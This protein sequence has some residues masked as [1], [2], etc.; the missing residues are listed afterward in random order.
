MDG[1][2]KIGAEMGMSVDFASLAGCRHG[3]SAEKY[4][5]KW[6]SVFEEAD[7]FVVTGTNLQSEWIPLIRNAIVAGKSALILID[8]NKVEVLNPLLAHFGMTITRQ[9]IANRNPSEGQNIVQ[10][11]RDDECMRAPDLF[12]GV[13]S[14]T[15]VLP[16][17]IWYCAVDD[18][19]PVLTATERQFVVNERDL[20]NNSEDPRQSA[21][22]VTWHGPK[23]QKIVAISGDV[24]DDPCESESGMLPGIDKNEQFARNLIRYL[25][26]STPV[27]P[28]GNALCDR[29]EQHLW[30]AIRCVLMGV[31]SE[32]DWWT[33]YVPLS[34]RQKCANRREEEENKYPSCG[35]LDLPDLE[36]ILSKNWNIFLPLFKDCDAPP[37]KADALNWIGQVNSKYRR[38]AAHPLKRAIAG[39]RYSNDDLTFLAKW[40]DFSRRLADVAERK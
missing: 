40:D 27:T 34:I 4:T 22:I 33:K 39:F 20:P 16:R 11:R 31:A 9:I 36:S 7:V 32:D 21:C 37:R 15:V 14:V 23:R 35:Y 30:L 5:A 10:F 2:H 18:A 25:D 1:F 17:V 29:I 26:R 6:H 24:L 28:D 13:E 8:P 38:M 19:F 3:E 12:G